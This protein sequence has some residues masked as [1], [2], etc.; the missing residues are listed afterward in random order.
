MLKPRNILSITLYSIIHISSISFYDTKILFEKMLPIT[1]ISV[2]L[3][4]FVFVEPIIASAIDYSPEIYVKGHL[5]GNTAGS[6]WLIDDDVTPMPVP[7][8]MVMDYWQKLAS[9]SKVSNKRDGQVISTLIDNCQGQFCQ[10]LTLEAFANGTQYFQIKTIQGSGNFTGATYSDK[11]WRQDKVG[12]GSQYE[13]ASLYGMNFE[14]IVESYSNW[15]SIWE[16]TRLIVRALQQTLYYVLNTLKY[17]S[18]Q[19]EKRDI[20]SI[21]VDSSDG[22]S[23]FIS[24]D[25]QTD[26]S[27]FYS[28]PDFEHMTREALTDESN[29]SKSA[30]CIFTNAVAG[31]EMNLRIIS[32]TSQS[33]FDPWALPCGI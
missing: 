29:K 20:Y 13:V 22:W 32:N 15:A 9:S 3:L 30:F 16:L 19:K 23:T 11:F 8:S 25:T 10:L 6:Y 21:L 17:C 28:W 4:T 1:Y 26:F 33:K 24:T 5:I 14:T 18:L 31:K 27:N 2:L 12:Y 7:Y